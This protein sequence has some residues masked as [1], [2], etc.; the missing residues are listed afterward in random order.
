MYS[1]GTHHI[2]PV[3]R[4]SDVILDMKCVKQL[5]VMFITASVFVVK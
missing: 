2:T 3:V 5:F 4:L 1:A